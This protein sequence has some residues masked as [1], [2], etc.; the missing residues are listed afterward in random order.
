MKKNEFEI[1]S[2]LRTK[3]IEELLSDQ[4]DEHMSNPEHMR[5]MHWFHEYS[6]QEE[7][8]LLILEG[9][10]FGN[11]NEDGTGK[12][13]INGFCEESDLEKVIPYGFK[14]LLLLQTVNAPQSKFPY[15]KVLYERHV[16]WIAK[17]NLI[18]L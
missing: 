3:T 8:R 17:Q 13:F 7:R 6:K 5:D 11:I 16:A 15:C 9:F 4:F 18:S 10:Y 14:G 12:K 1:G 2:L